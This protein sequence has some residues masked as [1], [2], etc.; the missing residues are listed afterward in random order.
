MILLRLISA[1]K[2]RVEFGYS[3][4][5]KTINGADL[6]SKKNL[7]TRQPRQSSGITSVP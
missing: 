3:G 4:I 6:G 1:G 2:V 7:N 5:C